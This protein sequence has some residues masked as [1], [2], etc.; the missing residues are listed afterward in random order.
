MEYH[1]GS[2]VVDSGFVATVDASGKPK[3]FSAGG[4]VW[5]EVDLSNFPTNWVAGDRI[6]VQFKI[7]PN[8]TGSDVTLLKG[9]YFA[10]A[11]YEFLEGTGPDTV[12]KYI[13]ANARTSIIQVSKVFK[14]SEMNNGYL[15]EIGYGSVLG[16]DYKFY[17][18]TIGTD[19]LNMIY[20]MW[21]LK[22]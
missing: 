14:Y 15:F 22:K 20:K 16:T 11:V 6:K 19:S 4:E 13:R 17:T 10:S 7:M 5:E 9:D 2:E 18:T 21:R 1:N 3:N 8:W 12:I